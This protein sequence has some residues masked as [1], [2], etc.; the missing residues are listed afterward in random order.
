MK[1]SVKSE[2]LAW[3]ASDKKTFRLEGFLGDTRGARGGILVMDELHILATLNLTTAGGVTL[4]GP[5]YANFIKK[6][7]IADNA[8][9]RRFITGFK[10]RTLM[11]IDM[12]NRVPADPATFAAAT[13][14][15]ATYEFVFKFTQK[16]AF[17]GFDFGLPLHDI[18]G[19]GVIELQMPT[20]TDLRGTGGDPT[21]NSGSYV[22]TAYLREIPATDWQFFAR[23]VVEE[24]SQSSNTDLYAYPKGRI[25]REAVIVKEAAS[26][27]SA[28][29]NITDVT[30]QPLKEVA[31]S[32]T[33]KKRGYLNERAVTSGQDPV[34]NDK[35]LPV[36]YGR[37]DAKIDDFPIFG[38]ELLVKL[39]STVTTPDLMVRYIAPKDERQMQIGAAR[40]GVPPSAVLEAK[41]KGKTK[42]NPNAWGP[43]KPFM[44]SK[45]KVRPTGR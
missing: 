31:I 43:Y 13:T 10:A 24:H 5:D 26:G 19:G 27:G 30:I 6:I 22:A 39:T 35:A 41:T 18:L 28:L 42:T 45:A 44:P 38:G 25:I 8:G 20:G 29:T 17:R 11:H 9:D 16:N 33:A 37:D 12:G 14:A 34:F 15:D 32:R 36:I 1:F 7:R 2:S 21:I 3:A 40:M 23:D 4:L